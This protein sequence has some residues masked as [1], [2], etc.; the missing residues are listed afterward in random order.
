MQGAFVFRSCV[1]AFAVAVPVGQPAAAGSACGKPKTLAQKVQRARDILEIQNVA[2]L[3]EYYHNAWRHRDEYRNIWAQKTPGVTWTNN[4]DKYIGAQSLWNFY[5]EGSERMPTAGVMAYHMLT[6]PVIEVAGDGQTAKGIWMSFG[7]VGG[8]MGGEGKA[9][10]AWTQEKYAVDFVKEDGHWKI[11][12]LRTYVDFYSPTDKSWMD[13]TAN[14]AGPPP[15]AA[16]PPPGG[17]KLE[18]TI[19]EEPG[20]SFK[21]AEPDEKGNYYEGYSIKRVPTL[22]PVLPQPYCSFS[23]TTPY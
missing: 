13:T 23:E 19:K 16:T 11:W 10:A 20:A 2:S 6:T 3:H 12:H 18:A 4:T 8:P 5:V 17:G 22:A 7:D 9:M 14:I 15:G 1:L 21:M